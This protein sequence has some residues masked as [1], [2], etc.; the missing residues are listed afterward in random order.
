MTALTLSLAD[1]VGAVIAAPAP[2]VT[3]GIVIAL[4]GQAEGGGP[5]AKI[6]IQQGDTLPTLLFML[7]DGNG[8]AY[9]LDTATVTFRLRLR[10]AAAGTYKINAA[11]TYVA[12]GLV[13]YALQAA[14][15][16]TAGEYFGELRMSFAGRV[17]TTER[18]VVRIKA[19]L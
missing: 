3:P 11:C 19:A 4:M 16:N 12:A 8:G 13:S 7:T 10:D 17:Y 6:T 2:V 18:F 9:D 14:D 15:V 5:A 1:G